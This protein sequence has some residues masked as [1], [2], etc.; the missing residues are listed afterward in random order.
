MCVYICIYIY[1]NTYTCFIEPTSEKRNSGCASASNL[2]CQILG[3]PEGGERIFGVVLLAEPA[4]DKQPTD[5]SQ[6]LCHLEAL[7]TGIPQASSISWR[8][9]KAERCKLGYLIRIFDRL[10]AV[11]S[12]E[13]ALLLLRP[14][15]GSLESLRGIPGQAENQCESS[16]ATRLLWRVGGCTPNKSQGTDFTLCRHHC[17]HVS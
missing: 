2:L 14:S 13:P 16:S 6:V 7:T 4:A 11:P 9:Q 8:R 12:R 1:M 10:D 5:R 17:M 3:L 15:L